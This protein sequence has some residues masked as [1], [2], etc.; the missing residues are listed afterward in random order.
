LVLMVWAAISV[1]T[2]KSPAAAAP[3][4]GS[5][6]GQVVAVGP[7]AL[8]LSLANGEWVAVNLGPNTAVVGP[9]GGAPTGSAAGIQAGDWAFATYGLVQGKAGG[10]AVWLVAR[11]V[12]WSASPMVFGKAVKVAGHVGQLFAGGFSL[13]AGSGRTWDVDVTAATQVYVRQKGRRVLSALGFVQA[14]DLAVVTGTAT[15]ST[16]A[17]T[18]VVYS[19]PHL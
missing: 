14:G 5:V 10:R 18:T 8:V 11:E 17:A 9:Q 13:V 12:E 3:A 15:G 16:I 19:L 1:G 2:L 7:H 4:S 6:Y